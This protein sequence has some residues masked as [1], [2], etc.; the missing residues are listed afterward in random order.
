MRFPIAAIVFVVFGFAFGIAF[1][2]AS[3]IINTVKDALQTPV[4]NLG[5]TEVTYWWT[6]IPL[7]F[8]VI[9]VI[10]FILGGV[11]YFF[12]DSTREESEYDWEEY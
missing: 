8:G 12:F 3:L 6:N 2:V 10:M 7:A 4:A 9:C 11:V 1:A 5:V